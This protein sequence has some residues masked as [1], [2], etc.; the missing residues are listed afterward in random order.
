M[1]D[2]QAEFDRVLGHMSADQLS[3]FLQPDAVSAARFNA[4]LAQNN[5]DVNNHELYTSIFALVKKKVRQDSQEKGTS[6]PN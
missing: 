6:S 3:Y 1:A 4:F 2:A 5:V